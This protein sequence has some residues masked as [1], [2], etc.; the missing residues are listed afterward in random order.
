MLAGLLTDTRVVPGVSVID[1]AP[2][3]PGRRLQAARTLEDALIDPRRN[4]VRSRGDIQSD[5]AASCSN[6]ARSG[7]GRPA[8]AESICT[9]AR[10]EHQL[11]RWIR[12]ILQA[13]IEDGNAEATGRR[14]ARRVSCRAGYR[15][16]SP[17]EART[18]SR[19]THDSHAGAVVRRG[20]R[21]VGD[22]TCRTYAD[23]LRRR[24]S[25][26]RRTCDGRSLR[27]VDGHRERARGARRGAGNR[28][29]TCWEERS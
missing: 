16:C 9:G 21:E 8:A 2:H 1:G 4:P 28:S 6:A 27:V 22:R 15:R 3:R 18:R 19:S 10:V 24:R 17:R 11:G 26:A 5:Y 29:G 25:D 14:V 20:R 7:V 23:V 13:H 12:I